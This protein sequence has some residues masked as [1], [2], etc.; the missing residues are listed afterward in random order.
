M[1]AADGISSSPSPS[2][3]FSSS[4]ASFYSFW[5]RAGQLT[6]PSTPSSPSHPH[7]HDSSPSHISS[8]PSSPHPFLSH[9]LHPLYDRLASMPV[10]LLH[11]GAMVR[12][13]EGMF[14]SAPTHRAL[15]G[16]VPTGGVIPAAAA[17]AAS[18]AGGGRTGRDAGD[19]AASLSAMVAPEGVREFLCTHYQVSGCGHY[20]VLLPGR[21]R[22]VHPWDQWLSHPC[23]NPFGSLIFRYYTTAQRADTPSDL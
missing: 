4:P 22:S 1:A 2:R 20:T 12:V 15:P 13:S 8:S 19:A 7:S 21:S 9:L 17:G 5:P 11:G 3:P 23:G 18:G 10:W 6:L 16:Q 14:L